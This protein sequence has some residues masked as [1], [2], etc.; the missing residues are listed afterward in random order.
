MSNAYQIKKHKKQ[1][2]FDWNG[3][4]LPPE[5]RDFV[6][7]G[8]IVRLHFCSELKG[9]EAALYVKITKVK[10]TN[11]S[12]EVLDRYRA[13]SQDIDESLKAVPNGKT[14][15][16]ERKNIYEIPLDWKENK[17]LQNLKKSK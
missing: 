12:G 15:E 1:D 7:I 14:V 3:N 11:L 13:L 8:N 9:W 17:N 4:R 10:G 6:N 5:T 2:L 16:F